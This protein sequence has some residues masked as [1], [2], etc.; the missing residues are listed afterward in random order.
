MERSYYATTQR[1]GRGVNVGLS[2]RLA[3]IARASFAPDDALRI[4]QDLCE[5]SPDSKDLLEKAPAP[6]LVPLV[7]LLISAPPMEDSLRRH[8]EWLSWLWSSTTTLSRVPDLADL[9]E[10]WRRWPQGQGSSSSL[11]QLRAFKRREYLRIAFLDISG[12]N[13]FANTVRWLSILAQWVIGIVLLESWSNLSVRRPKDLEGAPHPDGLAVVAMGK[14]GGNEINYS[15]DVDL[16]F[17]RRD[18]EDADEMRFFTLLCEKL[19]RSLAEGAADG[20]LYRVDMRLRPYGDSG[21]LVPTLTSLMNYHESWGES[22]ERQALIKAR[23]VTGSEPL[24]RRFADFVS[25][26]LFARQMDDSALEEIKR[27]K[28]RSERSYGKDSASIHLK[29]G[30]GGIRDIEFYVQYLQLIVGNSQQAVRQG[31][32]LEAISE[33]ARAKSLL[34]GEESRLSLAYLFLRTVEHRLQLQGLTP[35]AVLPKTMHELERLAEGLGFDGSGEVAVARF[36]STL[37]G[38][39]RDVRSIFERIYLVPGHLSLRDEQAEL[40]KLLTERTPVR[41][42]GDI[43]SRHQFKNSEKAWQN[44][45]LLAL[46]PAGRMLPPG[47]RRS[48][49]GIA[50][51][52]LDVLGRSI[53]PDRALHNLESFAASTGNRVSF[54]RA[55]AS[56]PSH[57]LRI[58]NLFALS[59]QCHQVLNRHPEFFDTLARGIHLDRGRVSSEMLQEIQERVNTLPPWKDSRDFVRMFRHREMLRVAYRDVSG[60][61]DAFEISSELSELA[62]ACL[63]SSLYLSGRDAQRL[64]AFRDT[65]PPVC[66]VALGKAGSRQMH[67]GSDLDLLFLYQDDDVS[68]S[69]STRADVQKRRDKAVEDL[70][71]FLSEVTSEGIVYPVDLRLRPEGATGLLARSWDSFQEYCHRHMQPWERLALVRSRVIHGSQVEHA[72]WIQLLSEAVYGF[73][74][75]RDMLDSIRHLKKRIE[76]EKNRESRISLDFKYG[77]GGIVDLEFLV[78]YLQIN[79]GRDSDSVRCPETVQAIEALESAGALAPREGRLLMEAYRFQRGVENHYQLVEEWSSREISREAPLI[80]PLAR[81]LGFATR[82]EGEDRKAFV[83]AW[84]KHS[85]FVRDLVEKFLYGL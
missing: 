2:D 37:A 71:A 3:S 14:L 18:S 64:S 70:V 59:N 79:H 62:E 83:E 20:F 63:Q 33:L 45:R 28:Y 65:S 16:V 10:Q 73:D 85:R 54:L 30:A 42:I 57:L 72:R 32:T 34:E 67:Y 31:A 38:Y 24:G 74:W 27:V 36:R 19:I 35:K 49:L 51:T 53:D 84:E 5:R 50:F 47:E 4:L 60:L 29:Q 41:R 26:F 80:A 43:L 82:N 76:K 81:S 69:E 21:P 6:F 1:N 75:R 40:A 22:W 78:Q 58:S 8:P 48:F 55:L 12:Q 25:R 77:R 56:Q 52:L 66:V 13:S 11:N 44:F 68:L 9:D 7:R 15:S 17:F 23:W 61:G 46:G 39:R